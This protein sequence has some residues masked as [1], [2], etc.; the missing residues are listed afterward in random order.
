MNGRT[1]TALG[2]QGDIGQKVG[3]QSNGRIIVAGWTDSGTGSMPNLDIG[4]V[5]YASNGILDGSFGA[6]GKIIT[7]I[8]A[9][10]DEGWGLDIQQNNKVVVVGSYWSGTRNEFALVRYNFNGSLDSSFGVGGKVTT[11][12]GRGDAGARSVVRQTDGK[13]LAAG[14]TWSGFDND[15]AIV[16]Y[17][18]DPADSDGDGVLDI[19]E[20][21][22][23][24]YV[25]PQNTGTSPNVIDTDG[26]G[27][28]DGAEVNLHSSN[29]N[30]SDTDGDGFS[31]GFEV[32]RGFSPISPTS[33]PDGISTALQAIEYRFNAASGVSYRIEASTDLVSW[34]TVE[35]PIIG[36]GGVIVR[37]YSIEG[38]PKRFFR[39]R[40]N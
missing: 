31:D 24:I 11:G 27:L 2:S 33:T 10:W 25:S 1:S 29:P 34:N 6:G 3:I 28:S 12:V 5:C 38:Q 18:G 32:A 17:E 14:S 8:G 9:A 21:G 39:S 30:V 13:F 35:T 36:N 4:I 23:G 7:S 15:F 26:D 40:R 22:T 20:T 37:F 19:Y 16:R